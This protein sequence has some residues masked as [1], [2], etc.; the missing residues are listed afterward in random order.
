MF[1]AAD[2]QWGSFT[3]KC[4]F[5]HGCGSHRTV[6]EHHLPDINASLCQGIAIL[7]KNRHQEYCAVFPLTDAAYGT[8]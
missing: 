4:R 7:A 2:Y 3:C 8:G 1:H 5:N 6:V